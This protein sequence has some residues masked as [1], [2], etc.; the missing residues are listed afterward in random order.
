MLKVLGKTGL[1]IPMKYLLISPFVVIL[2][3]LS[4][5]NSDILSCYLLM[6]LPRCYCCCITKCVQFFVT[7]ELAQIHASFMASLLNFIYFRYVD[8][9]IQVVPDQ[10]LCTWLSLGI[11]ILL[12]SDQLFL[13]TCDSGN[14][15]LLHGSLNYD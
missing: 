14:S 11:R 5:F 7:P 3:H 8:N 13:R 1:K 4:R 6:W 9:Y 12:I 15:S 10:S 2:T